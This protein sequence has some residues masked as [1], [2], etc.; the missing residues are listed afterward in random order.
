MEAA[1]GGNEKIVDELIKLKVDVHYKTRYD[2]YFQIVLASSHGCL[3]Y[4]SMLYLCSMDIQ[5]YGWL[6]IEVMIR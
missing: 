5:H 1:G 3:T 6:P 2:C 4:P